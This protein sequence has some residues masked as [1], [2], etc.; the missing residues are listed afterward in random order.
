MAAHRESMHDR[1]WG[2]DAWPPGATDQGLEGRAKKPK[3]VFTLLT[4]LSKTRK[5]YFINKTEC[6]TKTMK[7]INN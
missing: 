1:T 6:K 7:A 5:K 3:R 2:N 4:P